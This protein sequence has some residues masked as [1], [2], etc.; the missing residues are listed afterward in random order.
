M[1]KEV[2]ADKVIRGVTMPRGKR[3]Q[4]LSQFANEASIKG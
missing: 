1:V 4:I 3:E 2:S